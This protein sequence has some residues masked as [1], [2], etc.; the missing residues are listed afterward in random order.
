M[1][2]IIIGAMAVAPATFLAWIAYNWMGKPILDVR[3]ARI[4]ALKAAE[5]Y[6]FVGYGYGE[7]EINTARNALSNAAMSLRALSRG[8]PWTA[9]LYCNLLHYDLE[10]SS[11]VLMGLVG[12]TGANLSHDNTSRRDGSDAIHVLLNAGQHMTTERIKVIGEKVG[13]ALD[14]PRD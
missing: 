14:L 6:G 12:L 11:S 3:P 5:L 1:L 8:Q 10:L 4:E 7:D 13:T 2:N 9:K